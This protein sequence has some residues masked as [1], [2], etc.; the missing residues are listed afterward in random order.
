MGNEKY[1]SF[2]KE[3]IPSVLIYRAE[4]PYPNEIP[5]GADLEKNALKLI[6]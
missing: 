2:F 6:Q 5:R 1:D 3:N 4:I